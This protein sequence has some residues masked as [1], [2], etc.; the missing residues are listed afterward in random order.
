MRPTGVEPATFG[1]KVRLGRIFGC[2]SGEPFPAVKARYKPISPL[3]KYAARYRS[4]PS[5]ALLGRAESGRALLQ[6]SKAPAAM[7]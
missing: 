5:L 2:R 1:L 3:L 6:R 7:S 4:P